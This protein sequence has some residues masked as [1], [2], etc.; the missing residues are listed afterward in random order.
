MHNPT[1]R[2]E[3]RQMLLLTFPALV[4]VTVL[5]GIPLAML[6][7]LSVYENGTLT[8]R[9]YLRMIDDPSYSRSLWLT[10]Q[11]SGTVTLLAVIIGYPVAYLL[12][13]LPRRWAILGM[14]LVLIPFWTSL[15]VRTYAWLV[16]LQRRGVI[17]KTLINLGIIQ[18][19]LYLVHNVTGTIIGMLHIM[20]PFLILPLYAN[21]CR[22]DLTLV[23]AASSL[24]AS[25]RYAFWAV[26]LPLSFPG[27]LAGAL[28]VFV[29]SL[30]FYITPAILGGGRTIMISML[31]ERNV[32]L[33]FEWGAASSVAVACL[34]V[35]LGIFWLLSRALSVERVMGS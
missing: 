22:I 1:E 26:Y 31:M 35:V 13:Q 12:S 3:R 11:I 2:I 4:I 25:P 18:E 6:F 8:A 15:L 30:S 7:G 5:L 14:T 9:H 19:P 16:L 21:M 28:L 10:I 17:N 20:L 29:L 32:N 34:L 23:R 27:L 24:G 33:F